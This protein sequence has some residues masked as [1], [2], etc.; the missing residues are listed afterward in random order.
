[1]YSEYLH[2]IHA[3]Y[4]T[5]TF[6]SSMIAKHHH[7]VPERS[8]FCAKIPICWKTCNTGNLNLLCSNWQNFR[9][10]W[11]L[12]W[13]MCQTIDFWH[14][15]SNISRTEILQFV[16]ILA[17]ISKG[18]DKNWICTMWHGDEIRE[19]KIAYFVKRKLQPKRSLKCPCLRFSATPPS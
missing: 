9:N 12:D 7:T 6:L 19:P 17:K 11:E 15:N 16:W 13:F 2:G 1:M 18:L 3:W 10:I 5:N 14:E 4:L 8:I